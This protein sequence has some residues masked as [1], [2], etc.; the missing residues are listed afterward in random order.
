MGSMDLHEGWPQ[1]REIFDAS[2]KSSLHCAIASVDEAGA[3]HVTPVGHIFLRDDR[4]AFFFDE[5]LR[6]LRENLDQDPRVCL[7]LV[8]SNRW[9]WLRSLLCGRFA[10]APGVRLIGVA[11]SRRTATADER[12]AYEARVRSF[13]RTR[14]YDLIW[15]DLCHVRDIEITA[16]S[17][18]VYPTM[19]VSS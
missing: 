3:P 1:V 6:K 8:N 17:P 5:H 15:K 11:G 13:R 9:F 7:L 16:C 12:A 10:S 2:I 19:P 14:G 4:T 18:V